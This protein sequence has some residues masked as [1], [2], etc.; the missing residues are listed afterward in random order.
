MSLYNM[1]Q[2]IYHWDI[3]QNT[4]EWFNIRKGRMTGSN[5]QAIGNNGKGLDTLCYYTMSLKY[6][7]AEPDNYTNEHLERGKQLEDQACELYSLENSANLRKIGFISIG[8]YIGV[9][10]DRLLEDKG[11]LEIKCPDDK[12]YF[13]ILIK[14]WEEIDTAYEWQCQMQMLVTNRDYCILKY[15]N[16]NFVISSK[17]FEIKADK[18]KFEQLEIG[19]A[20]GEKMMKELEEKYL[21]LTKK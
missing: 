8:D 9:S 15:Y 1:N 11:L 20:K 17:I 16:P 18:E 2:P 12:N 10:P 6:S 19:L 7:S 5:A 21:S 4:P 14:G 13:K 3:E